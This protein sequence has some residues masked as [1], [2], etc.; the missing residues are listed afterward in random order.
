MFEL[1]VLSGI[2]IDE[3]YLVPFALILSV[4]G[5]GGAK[6]YQSAGLAYGPL[7]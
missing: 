1:K 4:G 5:L 6:M 2:V 3:I 7:I